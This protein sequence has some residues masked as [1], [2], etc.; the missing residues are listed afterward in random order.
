MKNLILCVLLSLTGC[1]IFRPATE[2]TA[3][4]RIER[5]SA[6]AELAAYTGTAVRLVDHPEDRAK[7]QAAADALGAAS[8]GDSTAL[9][10]VLSTLPVKELKGDKGAIIIGAA[11][12]LYET[13]LKRLTTIDQTSL[14]GAVSASIRAGITRALTQFPAK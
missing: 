11:V 6:I 1:S 10:R 3:A 13:E 2:P 14:V 4:Q 8:A 7:F 9:Q 12:L 5:V